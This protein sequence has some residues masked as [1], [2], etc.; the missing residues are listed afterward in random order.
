LCTIG[1]ICN[2]C[3][4]CVA[5]ATL[6]KC[7]AEPS[8]NPR[9]PAH[10]SRTT[11]ARTHAPAIK[12]TR[13]LRVRRYLQRGRSISSILRGCCNAN[14][15]CYMLVLGLCLVNI[16][17]SLPN[18]VVDV[19]SVNLLKACLDKFWMDQD[20]KCDFTVDLTGT[21]DRSCSERNN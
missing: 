11:H 7:V 3:T 4:G 12:S 5:M 6:R 14:A 17:N 19:N 2:R 21:S 13:L 10:A 9:G 1:R 20:V 18:H 15:K 16:W 8:G